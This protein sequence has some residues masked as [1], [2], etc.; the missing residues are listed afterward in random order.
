[1]VNLAQ[2]VLELLDIVEGAD[3]WDLVYRGMSEIEQWMKKKYPKV[4]ASFQKGTYKGRHGKLLFSDFALACG[5]S[6]IPKVMVTYGQMLPDGVIEEVHKQVRKI[7]KEKRQE[8][9]AE[10]KK[11][12]QMEKEV[13][14]WLQSKCPEFYKC[15]TGANPYVTFNVSGLIRDVGKGLSNW[16]I[17]PERCRISVD[18]YKKASSYVKQIL[19]KYGF[20]NY[21]TADS[22]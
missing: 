6:G 19:K 9:K 8:R 22:G 2:E 14:K 17:Y 12:V 21:Y 3:S 5:E 15:L 18:E 11:I 4:Y 7:M 10:D 20:E 16:K 1:M 13:G